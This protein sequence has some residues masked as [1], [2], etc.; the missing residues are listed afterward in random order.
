M[1]LYKLSSYVVTT[2][3][4][5]TSELNSKVVKTVKSLMDEEKSRTQAMFE[6]VAP[7]VNEIFSALANYD[8]RFEFDSLSLDSCK[9]ERVRENEFN[10]LCPLKE[11]P[12]EDL[13]LEGQDSTGVLTVR[14]SRTYEDRWGNLNDFCYCLTHS[15]H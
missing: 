10:V 15:G 1:P 4:I 11:L 14:L 8:I 5:L 2:E 6:N 7:L 9:F 3:Q 13:R 12:E